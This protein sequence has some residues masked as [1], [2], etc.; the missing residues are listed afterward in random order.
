MHLNRGDLTL[1]QTIRSSTRAPKTQKVMSCSKNERFK[2]WG[3]IV[4]IFCLV[5]VDI[6][7]EPAFVTTVAL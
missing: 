7:M 1:G 6:H 5:E 4:R 2:V 3:T